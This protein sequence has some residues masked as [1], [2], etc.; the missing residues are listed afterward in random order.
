MAVHES[1]AQRIVV[2]YHLA[3][4]EREELPE[5]LTHRLCPA[6]CELPQFEFPA[7][8][9]LFQD[10]QGMSCNV[11]RL[12][13]YALTSTAIEKAKTLGAEHVQA[14]REVAHEYPKLAFYLRLPDYRTLAEASAFHE[15]LN[16]LAEAIWNCDVPFVSSPTR[17][18]TAN[19]VSC[20]KRDTS[21]GPAA[22][23]P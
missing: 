20:K 9:A 23:A 11:N 5:Y 18:L 3:G 19:H 7:I 21:E 15:L 1:P 8:E 2:R 10:T 22:L 13:Y 14:A 17:P 16:N 12:D 4:L 6:G